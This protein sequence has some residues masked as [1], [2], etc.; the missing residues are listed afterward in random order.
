MI[1][2][3]KIYLGLALCLGAL[4]PVAAAPAIRVAVKPNIV[5][6]TAQFFLA[7]PNLIMAGLGAAS[8]AYAKHC[9]QKAED[10]AA[11]G[12]MKKYERRGN[13][14]VRVGAGLL[15]LSA[16]CFIQSQLKKRGYL[17]ALSNITAGLSAGLL[18]LGFNVID[19]GVFFTTP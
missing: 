2:I 10:P 7:R 6:A 16:N 14:A 8:L 18:A 5:K 3:R 17:P 11:N 4:A 15:G 12:D 13:L 19:H 1:I 9:A